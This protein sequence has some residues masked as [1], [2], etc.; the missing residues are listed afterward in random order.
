VVA[1]ATTFPAAAAFF[2]ADPGDSFA[3]GDGDGIVMTRVTPAFVAIDDAFPFTYT[4]PGAQPPAGNA[5]NLVLEVGPSQLT[6]ITDMVVTVTGSLSGLLGT[7]PVGIGQENVALTAFA[8][9]DPA[10]TFTVRVTGLATSIGGGAYSV[11]VAFGQV[12][13]LPAAAVLLATGLAGLGVARRLRH[14]G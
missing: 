1:L 7:T 3:I 10:E 8:S 6:E 11:G 13:P 9:F 12:V 4:G 2:A 14:P 5:S